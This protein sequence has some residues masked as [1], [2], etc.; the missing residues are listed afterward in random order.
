MENKRKKFS[1]EQKVNLLRLHLIEKEPVS[2]IC[3]RHGLAP[4]V[5]YQW[6]KMFFENGAAAF[7]QSGAR[8]TN[9]NV[10]ELERQ[11]TLS[12]A[13]CTIEV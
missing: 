7:T 9:N 1:P 11:T 3:D 2:N 10:K 8:C 12:V 13:E 5:F 4:N 6:Q